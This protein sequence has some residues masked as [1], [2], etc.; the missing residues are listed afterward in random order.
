[1]NL[2]VDYP[3]INQFPEW[4]VVSDDTEYRLTFT[5]SSSAEV[6]TGKNLKSGFPVKFEKGRTYQLL[7][8]AL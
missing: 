8:Q 6:L 2:P 5:G 4:F 7:V 1:M 3:R